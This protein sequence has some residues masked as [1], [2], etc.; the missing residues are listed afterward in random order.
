[1]KELSILNFIGGAQSM[2]LFKALSKSELKK[3]FTDNK[4]YESIIADNIYRCKSY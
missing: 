4:E 2:L 3:I 1:M